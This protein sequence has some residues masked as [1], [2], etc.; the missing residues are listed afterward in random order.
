MA[1]VEMKDCASII[2]SRTGDN[3]GE[4]RIFR[5]GDY[6]VAHSRDYALYDLEQYYF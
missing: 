2:I 4:G 1:Y 6:L 3:P 5:Q